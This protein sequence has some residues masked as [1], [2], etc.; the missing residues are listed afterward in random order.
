MLYMKAV[1]RI[2]PQVLITRKSIFPFS[3]LFYLY[4]VMNVH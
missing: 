1:K 4:E 3:F 2:S